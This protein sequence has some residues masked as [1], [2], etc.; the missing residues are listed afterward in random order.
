MES[1]YPGFK[2]SIEMTDVATP[3]TYVRYTGSWKGTFMT[4]VQTPKNTQQI[5]M[6][7]KTV[8]DLENFWLS[9]MWVAAPGGVP[10]GLKSSR[11]VIQIICKKDNKRF[12]TEIP[13]TAD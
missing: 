7:K 6:I 13:N 10:G 3:M 5:R 12:R 1:I 4:W 9:G 8:P 11:D 2:D